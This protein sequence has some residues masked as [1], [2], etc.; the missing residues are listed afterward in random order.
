V[1]QLPIIVEQDLRERDYG[2]LAGLAYADAPGRATTASATG[3]GGPTTG[4]TLEEV[5]GGSAPTLDRTAAAGAEQD[6][7]VV[8][9]GAVMMAAYRHVTGL[10]RR[11]AVSYETPD[12][13]RRARRRF[14]APDDRNSW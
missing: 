2:R 10:G 4:E 3:P 5:L 8:S 11:P 1:L 9:H 12:R 13:R 14:L 7:V 6:V